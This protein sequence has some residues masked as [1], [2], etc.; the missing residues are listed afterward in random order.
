MIVKIASDN[1][2][3]FHGVRKTG[4]ILDLPV[5]E[6]ISL[7]KSGDAEAEGPAENPDE[8]MPFARINGMMKPTMTS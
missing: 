2:R 8:T 1:I 3:T 4:D 5:H 7:I 6:A